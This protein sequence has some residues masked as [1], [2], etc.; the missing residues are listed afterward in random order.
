MVVIKIKLNYCR[1][2]L[3]F[4]RPVKKVLNSEKITYV[5]TKKTVKLSF[6]GLKTHKHK[7]Y[8]P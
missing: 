3:M 7:I 6:C 4:F 2:L 1:V 5:K 8:S